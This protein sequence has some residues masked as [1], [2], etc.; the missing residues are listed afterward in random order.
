MDSKLKIFI[1]VLVF[2]FASFV[3]AQETA[4]QELLDSLGFEVLALPFDELGA[5]G[6]S[7]HCATVDVCREGECED[8]F[9]RQIPGY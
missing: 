1:L 3:E 9:P 7:F 6:G 2:H 8:Y 5:F 4:H